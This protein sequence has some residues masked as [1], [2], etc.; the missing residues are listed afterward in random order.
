LVTGQL[1]GFVASVVTSKE[2]Q[3]LNAELKS[4]RERV[5]GDRKEALRVLRAAGIADNDGQL[6]ACY[7][8]KE[9]K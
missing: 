3:T 2:L 1:E 4:T 5:K 9:A 7:R 8:V 6:A